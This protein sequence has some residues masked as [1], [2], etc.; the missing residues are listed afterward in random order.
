MAEDEN[1]F[2]TSKAITEQYQAQLDLARGL[3]K[4]LAIAHG[5][6]GK[7]QQIYKN[8]VA[9]MQN[10]ETKQ[11]VINH[12]E[13]KRHDL[14]KEAVQSGEEVNQTLIDQLDNQIKVLTKMQE[15]EDT[16][17]SIKEQ[18]DEWSS[19][20][21]SYKDKWANIKNT[22][23]AAVTDPLAAGIALA[24]FLISKAVEYGKEIKDTSLAMGA[25]VSQGAH[26][27]KVTAQA[28]ITADLL[29]GSYK[30]ALDVA[31]ALS[32]EL[33]GVDAVTTDAVNNATILSLRYG[34]GAEN[35]AKLERVF[36]DV[37]DGTAAGAE[38]MRGFVADLASANGVAP[39][40]VMKDIAENSEAFAR[41]G[42]ESAE[43][44]VKASIATKKLGIEMS[45][46]VSAADGLLNIEDS[47]SKQMEAEVLIG[48]QLNLDKARQAALQ[49]DYLTLTK[50]LVNQV[51]SIEEFNS[52][53]AIQQQALADSLG[54]SV[55]ETRK[56]VENQD[57]I[58]GL[59][60]EALQHYKET[61]EIQE[62]SNDLLS[63]ENLALAS[64]I[65]SGAAAIAQL[66]TQLGLRTSIFGMAKATSEVDSDSSGG[67]GQAGGLMEKFSKIKMSDVLKGAAAMLIVAAAV[68][69]FAKAV[70]EFMNVSWEAVGMAVVSMLALVGAVALLGMIMMSGVGAIAIIAGAAAMLI[71]AAAMLVLA[72][73]LSII[74]EAIPNFMLFIPMLPEMAFGFLTLAPL[75]PILPFLGFGLIAFGSGMGISAIGVGFFGAVGGPAIISELAQSMSMLVP[76]TSGIAM[77]GPAFMSMA[78]GIA[79]LAAS[80][81]ILTPMLPTLLLLGGVAGGISAMFSAGEDEGGD[82]SSSK[83][84]AK[85]DEL[86]AAVSVPGVVKMDGKKVG[87]VLNMAS[88]PLGM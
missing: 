48:R 82:D 79:T 74:S 52:M 57:K 36:Q 37:T 68:F 13:A 28:G 53:N 63:A 4:E 56:M 62:E 22:V 27:G 44:F 86:I 17:K 77:L 25:T 19:S 10:L 47:I 16:L 7:T 55:G 88:A 76:L 24:G 50:E 33:G 2:K 32:T 40:A 81:F 41:Y 51:G 6:L 58:A 42:A 39:G 84:I 15:Q 29:G 65:V 14:I 21:D 8:M 38:N 12:L 1:K 75:L 70:Q 67:G 61:G 18:Q 87:E 59:S 5:E 30:D 60:E 45:S 23:I 80:L 26:L 85:L 66:A 35:A 71:V 78:A 20:M 31:D 46:L 9:E 49:G 72:V 3:S 54:M 69:V 34:L 83:I 73:A 11:E 43:D 64:T